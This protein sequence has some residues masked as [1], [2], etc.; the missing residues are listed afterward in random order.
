[1]ATRGVVIALARVNLEGLHDEIS[2]AL[3]AVFH[4]LASHPLRAV[5]D[6][7]APPNV[8][9]QIDALAAAHDPDALTAR[10]AALAAAADAD[11]RARAVPGWALWSEQQAV[12]YLQADV[13]DLASAKVALVA[14]AR[15]LVALRD[16]Q[17]PALR[18]E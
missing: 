2:A 12:E 7:S 4:G 15:V 18:A 16:A 5:V 6:A 8:D 3:G 9:A 17:W 13:T 1:M 10:Q 11:Q 14:M